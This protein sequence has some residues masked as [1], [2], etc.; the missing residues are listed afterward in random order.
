VVAYYRAVAEASELPLVVYTRDWAAFGAEFVARLA[1]AIPAFV[2][3]KDGQGDIRAL[4]RLQ[5]RLGDRLAWLGGVGDDLAIAYSV[6]GMAGF[7]SSMFNYA[8]EIVREIWTAAQGGDIDRAR[9]LSERWVVPIFALR[10]RRAGYEVGVTKTAM[11]VVGLPAGHVRPPLHDLLAE[12]VEQVRRVLA[13]LPS[14]ALAA[15]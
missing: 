8:P 3:L 4:G 10:T 15:G 11:Q 1:D 5:A 13:D 7:T 2:G 9:A 14:A 12:E 6:A